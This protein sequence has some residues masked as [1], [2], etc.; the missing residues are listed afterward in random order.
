LAIRRAQLGEQRLR[1]G[2]PAAAVISA[3]SPGRRLPRIRLLRLDEGA[4]RRLTNLAPDFN[5]RDFDASPDGRE[6]VF[7][8]VQERSNV[9]LIDLAPRD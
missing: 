1:G 4:E 2:S 7:E 5:V 3:A 6:I 8:R 9:V